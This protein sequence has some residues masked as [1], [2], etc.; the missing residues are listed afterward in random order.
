MLPQWWKF[1]K[2]PEIFCFL[3]IPQGKVKKKKKKKKK[4]KEEEEEEEE[5]EEQEKM[6]SRGKLAPFVVG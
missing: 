4:K 1:S 2:L 6:T 5:E 3:G